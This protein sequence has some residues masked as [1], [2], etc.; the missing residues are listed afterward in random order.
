MD[1]CI[2]SSSNVFSRVLI[3]LKIIPNTNLERWKCF[4]KFFRP[5]KH[6]LLISKMLFLHSF[7]DHLAILREKR[8]KWRLPSFSAIKK[9]LRLYQ[10]LWFA[11]LESLRPKQQVKYSSCERWML[12]TE[13]TTTFLPKFILKNLEFLSFLSNYE[14]FSGL[15]DSENKNVPIMYVCTIKNRW[16]RHITV[17]RFLMR[18]N[19]SKDNL[20]LRFGTIYDAQK[21][22]RSMLYVGGKLK[23]VSFSPQ[24]R[25]LIF[26]KKSLKT[27]MG[28]GKKNM[29]CLFY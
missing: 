8:K 28:S 25:A 13:A 21:K 14:L 26:Q 15:S 10:T 9:R 19:Y 18:C 20:K 22:G 12:E 11:F 4:Q 16:V 29:H 27:N 5:Y 6:Q 1:W 17:K 3:I 24:H 23:W 2:A 7:G